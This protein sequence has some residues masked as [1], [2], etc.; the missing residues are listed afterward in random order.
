MAS[1]LQQAPPTAEELAE[2]R[3]N[4]V[5]WNWYGSYSCAADPRLVVRDRRG[6]GWTL[7]MAHPRANL[8]MGLTVAAILGGLLLV[9]LYA[10]R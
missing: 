8:V 1:H 6:L 9:G 5:H 10:A 3:A 7:N 2:F 4:P